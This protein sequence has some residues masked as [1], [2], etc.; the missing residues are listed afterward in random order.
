MEGCGR[1]L[2]P[3]RWSLIGCQTFGA[4]RGAERG[5]RPQHSACPRPRCW[6][7]PEPSPSQPT[8]PRRGR[9]GRAGRVFFP[10]V[11][12]AFGRESVGAPDAAMKERRPK[13]G[14][15]L[16]RLP[17]PRPPLP[18]PLLP[19]LLLAGTVTAAAGKNPPLPQCS[20]FCQRVRVLTH[21]RTPMRSARGRESSEQTRLIKFPSAD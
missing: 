7:L 4:V 6:D 9:G 14:A 11:R 3:Q 10:L 8:Q 12:S 5:C 19:L 1:A 15:A 21:P 13:S 20:V 16:A 2:V 17:R 18:L